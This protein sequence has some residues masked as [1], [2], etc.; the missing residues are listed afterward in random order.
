MEIT[1]KQRKTLEKYAHDISPVVIVGG[2]GVTDG[3]IGMVND[4]LEA[5][6]LIKVKFNEY[7]DEKKELA[8]EISEKC[9]AVLV[10]LIGNVLILY[11]PAEDEKKRKIVI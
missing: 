11:R 10:R 3:L 1:S 4:S 2:A 5:H 9:N 6:E 8:A 7:K